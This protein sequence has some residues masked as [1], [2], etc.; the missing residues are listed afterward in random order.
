MPVISAALEVDKRR[1]KFKVSWV[2]WWW[3][4]PVAS[5]MLEVGIGE[6]QSRLARA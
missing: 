6:S 2:W 1:Q 5:A 4:T 3:F